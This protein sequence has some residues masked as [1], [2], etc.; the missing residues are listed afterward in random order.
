V[1]GTASADFY[2][3]LA[4]GGKLK[5]SSFIRGSELLRFADDDL[6]KAS[7]NVPFP[8]GSS[9]YLIRKGLLSCSYTGCAFV[10]YPLNGLVSPN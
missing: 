8:S 10:F 5:S 2:V 1:K 7:F 4:P 9:A 6:A 3:V